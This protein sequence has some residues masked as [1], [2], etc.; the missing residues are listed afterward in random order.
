MN[1]HC[2]HRPK[3]KYLHLLKLL[4]AD[5]PV[6]ENPILQSPNLW[7]ILCISNIHSENIQEPSHGP[8]FEI[9]IKSEVLLGLREISAW[10]ISFF[11]PRKQEVSQDPLPWMVNWKSHWLNV[12]RSPALRLPAVWTFGF[13]TLT[14]SLKVFWVSA[15]GLLLSLLAER[16]SFLPTQGKKEKPSTF[17]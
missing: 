8:M 13:L 9:H 6:P 14:K 12:P 5:D 1:A 4:T 2:K 10:L 3:T 11:P 7:R 17:Q 16:T 15:H